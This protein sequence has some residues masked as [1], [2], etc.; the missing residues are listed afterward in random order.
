MNTPA[1]LT[2]NVTTL[3]RSADADLTRAG[4]TWYADAHNHALAIAGAHNISTD[5]AA[6]IIAAL[7]PMNSWGSNIRLA[8]RFVEAGG[9]TSGYLGANLRKAQRILDGEDPRAVLTSHK[10]SAFFECI[11]ANGETDAVCIDRHAIDLATKTRHTDATRPRLTPT[12]YAEFADTYRRAA[13]ILTREGMAVS[14]AQVQAVTWVAWRRLWWSEG[15]F[16]PREA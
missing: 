9:L 2:R 13:R 1:P 3:F 8:T 12:R 10:V 15:A 16:D 5:A 6:G 11:V 4:L 7:S 14:A